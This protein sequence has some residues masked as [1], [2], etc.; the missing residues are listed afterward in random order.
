M[1]TNTNVDGSYVENIELVSCL[2]V[3]L[4]SARRMTFLRKA[5]DAYITQSYPCRELIIVV[6]PQ[7]EE[8]GGI[9][10]DEVK[11]RQRDDIR[12]VRPHGP[13]TLGSLRNISILEA[14]GT[15]MCQWDDDDLYHPKRIERQLGFLV[16][17][18]LTAVALESVMHFVQESSILYQTSWRMTPPGAMPA[19]IMWRKSEN[20]AYPESGPEAALGEDLAVLEQLKRSGRF[21]ALEGEPFLYINVAH[22]SNTCGSAHYAMIA[23]RLAVSAKYLRIREPLY[24]ANLFAFDLGN[25]EIHVCGSNGFAFTI[26]PR[27]LKCGDVD[28]EPSGVG[29]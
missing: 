25:A 24:R 29:A 27:A 14:R 9:L 4:G 22:G 6:D 17:G 2:I 8:A 21:K 18:D 3:T 16:A 12:I 5:I 10:E 15:I 7:G 19:S 20:V 1:K 28:K 26:L 13:Q 23:A 11:R